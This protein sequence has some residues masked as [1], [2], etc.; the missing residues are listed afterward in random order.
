[1]FKDNGALT[2]F[3]SSKIISSMKGRTSLEIQEVELMN[4]L[5]KVH[6]NFDSSVQKK[7]MEDEDNFSTEQN[8]GNRRKDCSVGWLP[9]HFRR[10]M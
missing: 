3:S 7:I 9:W 6:S 2:D 5:L 1:M 8:S 4:C 10:S